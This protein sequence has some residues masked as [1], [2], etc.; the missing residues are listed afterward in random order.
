MNEVEIKK[1]S[2]YIENDLF[3][4]GPNWPHHLFE[5]RSYSRWAAF[6]ILHRLMDYP[7]DQADVIIDGFIFEM[8]MFA[9]GDNTNG[10]HIFS[11]AEKV[12]RDILFIL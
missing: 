1:I 4:P 8:S 3:E 7:F 12:A 2:Q 10:R 5:E 6:E 9:H 11:I